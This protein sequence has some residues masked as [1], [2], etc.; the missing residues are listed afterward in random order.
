MFYWTVVLVDGVRNIVITPHKSE[1]LVGDTVDCTA[2]GN[3]TPQITWQDVTSP[4]ATAS[5]GQ[6][7]VIVKTMIGS[8]KWT[9]TASNDVHSSLKQTIAFVVSELFYWCCI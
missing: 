4:R 9:C 2:E 5:N 1:Y 3:P 6:R 8:N 7:L